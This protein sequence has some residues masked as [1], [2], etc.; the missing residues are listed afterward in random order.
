[1]SDIVM[2][3]V[4]VGEPE[5]SIP[6]MTEGHPRQEQRVTHASRAAATYPPSI[7]GPW[8]LPSFLFLSFFLRLAPA[9]T[10]LCGG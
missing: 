10:K 1:M 2:D 6:V 7:H 8:L 5:V 4:G 3:I 9:G